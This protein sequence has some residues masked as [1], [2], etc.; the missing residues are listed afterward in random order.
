MYQVIE[1]GLVV[2]EFPCE[3]SAIK[4]VAEN[5]THEEEYSKGVE[6]E[7]KEG[8]LLERANVAS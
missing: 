8:S 6:I 1:S 3:G 4:Y 5:Y 2:A 7:F